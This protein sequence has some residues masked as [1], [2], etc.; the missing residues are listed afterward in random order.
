MNRTC[1][2][3]SG[4]PHCL[5]LSC[6]GVRMASTWEGFPIPLPAERRKNPHNWYTCS[7]HSMQ[8]MHS[9]SCARTVLTLLWLHVKAAKHPTFQYHNSTQMHLNST[10]DQWVS[11]HHF[12][13]LPRDAVVH[14][15]CTSTSI[16]LKSLTHAPVLRGVECVG[17]QFTHRHWIN[18]RT[19]PSVQRAQR[20]ERGA[21]SKVLL[22][23]TVTA[24][25]REAEF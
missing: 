12:S 15:L 7:Y 1:M 4:K 8:L 18:A 14:A 21:R 20:G 22:L 17:R 13:F 3:A 9:L 23:P 19:T 24:S 2:V 11:Y 16:P 6:Y 10:K 25:N 5:T